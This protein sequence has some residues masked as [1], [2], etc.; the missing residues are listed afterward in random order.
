MSQAEGLLR[1]CR[2]VMLGQVGLLRTVRGCAVACWGLRS[3]VPFMRTSPPSD[4]QG[5]G[6]RYKGGTGLVGRTIA[7][8]GVAAA[9]GGEADP[10]SKR[11]GPRAL[12]QGLLLALGGAGDGL[13]LLLLWCLHSQTVA[14]V[15]FVGIGTETP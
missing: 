10:A 13:W 2:V 8:R 12:R 1:T 15:T 7:M 14:L 3:A 4:R 9:G 11:C 6:A 5:S